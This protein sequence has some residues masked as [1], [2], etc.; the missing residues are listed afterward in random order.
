MTGERII[1]ILPFRELPEKL[2]EKVVNTFRSWLN[3][4][5]RIML[6]K[7]QIAEM[8]DQLNV[9][10]EF[11]VRISADKTEKLFRIDDG[12]ERLA[13]FLAD[14]F[15]IVARYDPDVGHKILMNMIKRNEGD[16]RLK[17]K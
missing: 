3:E 5:Y 4:V 14:Q 10:V 11:Y 13:K 1:K 9:P 17:I 16:E 8:F 7:K 12:D 6:F 2:K 15:A